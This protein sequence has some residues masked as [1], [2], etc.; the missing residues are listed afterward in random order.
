MRATQ[1]VESHVQ[2]DG[3]T[4]WLKRLLKPLPVLSCGAA[5]I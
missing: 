1:I 5:C 4:V 2:R 3:C